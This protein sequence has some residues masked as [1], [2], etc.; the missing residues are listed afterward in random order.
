MA[1][2]LLT[3]AQRATISEVSKQIFGHVGAHNPPLRGTG[4]KNLRNKM[5][6]PAIEGYFNILPDLPKDCFPH[7]GLPCVF[8]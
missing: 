8:G 5:Y 4:R 2:R 3:A 7:G 1:S 6:G